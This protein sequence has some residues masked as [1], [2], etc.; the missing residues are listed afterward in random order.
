MQSSARQLDNVS[1]RTAVGLHLGTNVC[2]PHIWICSEEVNATRTH[3]LSCHKSAV[4]H[5]RYNAVN[6]LIKYQMCVG[7]SREICQHHS[8]ALTAKPDGSTT[9]PWVH[10]YSLLS[11]TR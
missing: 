6:D 7:V 10:R 9:V 8:D 2:A 11:Q 1:L 5:F 3:G 4:R